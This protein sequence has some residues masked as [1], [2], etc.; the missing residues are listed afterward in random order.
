[1]WFKSELLK[2]VL[3]VLEYAKLCKK[4]YLV[5]TKYKVIFSAICTSIYTSHVYHLD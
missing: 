2:E 3:H 5:I 1:M 4:L